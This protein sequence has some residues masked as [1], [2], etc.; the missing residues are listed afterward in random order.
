MTPWL[1]SPQVHEHLPIYATGISEFQSRLDHLQIEQAKLAEVL[2]SE[3]RYRGGRGSWRWAH[4][5]VT[6]DPWPVH[7]SQL[8]EDADAAAKDKGDSSALPQRQA[9]WQY[10]CL[11]VSVRLLT[12]YNLKVSFPMFPAELAYND[13]QI[14]KSEKWVCVRPRAA[15]EGFFG[16]ELCCNLPSQN[17]PVVPRQA[18]QV[19]LQ[20]GLHAAVQRAPDHNEDV[21]QVSVL[22]HAT[23]CQRQSTFFMFSTVPFFFQIDHQWFH[24]F[25]IKCGIKVI[26]I[27]NQPHHPIWSLPNVCQA[28]IYVCSE[29]FSPYVCAVFCWRCT[30]GCR[31]LAPFPLTCCQTWSWSS[32]SKTRS[33]FSPCQQCDWISSAS[34]RLSYILD[35]SKF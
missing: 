7:P 34:V 1:P 21:E 19:S 2:A 35:S 31:T 30:L 4:G 22:D 6:F 27:S 18:S 24:V 8:S 26:D 9:H 11:F 3:K 28:S 33:V 16:L 13:E 29:I 14:H 17:P 20:G 10:V 25:C 15:C 5:W 32:S 12:L 23:R